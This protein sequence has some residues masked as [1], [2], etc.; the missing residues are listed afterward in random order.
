M[1]PSP[2]SYGVGLLW[3]GV[4]LWVNLF[5]MQ[6]K[7][8]QTDWRA[9]GYPGFQRVSCIQSA[10]A[11]TQRQL[12]RAPSKSFNPPTAAPKPLNQ[13]RPLAP[14]QVLWVSSTHRLGLSFCQV[15]QSTYRKHADA[16][17]DE[18]PTEAG[19]PDQIK[20]I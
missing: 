4:E 12:H 5:T 16:L 15:Q 18:F 9:C 19:H 17:S 14:S 1:L 7:Q 10:V 3:I 20:T 8:T 13:I 6:I 2:H 11:P